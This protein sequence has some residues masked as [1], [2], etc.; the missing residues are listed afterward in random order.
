MSDAAPI[1]DASV[2]LPD[3]VDRHW[4][5]AARSLVIALLMADPA[6]AEL[7]TAAS[8]AREFILDRKR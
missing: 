8:I 1:G 3:A 7:E 4:V 5:E 2:A 6:V